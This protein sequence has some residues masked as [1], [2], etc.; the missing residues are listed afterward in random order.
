MI[1]TRK[2]GFGQGRVDL[3][4]ADLVEKDGRSALAAPKAG[5]EVMQALV[6]VGRNRAKA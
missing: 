5:D 6:D 1:V 4:V 2:L 3:V